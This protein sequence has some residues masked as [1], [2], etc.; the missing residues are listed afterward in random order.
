MKLEM[1]MKMK[2]DDESLSF[3]CNWKQ[4]LR[5]LAALLEIGSRLKVKFNF[6][7]SKTPLTRS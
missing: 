2:R 4:L 1:K 5:G 7:Y 6:S 3:N